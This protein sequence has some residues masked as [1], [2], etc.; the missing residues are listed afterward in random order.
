MEYEYKGRLLGA[1]IDVETTGFSPVMDEVIELCIV[2]FECDDRGSLVIEDQYVGLRE[3]SCGIRAGAQAV[4]GISWGDVCGQDLDYDRVSG[5]IRR[6]DFLVAHNATFDRSFV[7][8]LLPLADRKRWFCSMAGIDWRGK[9]YPSRGLQELLR[10]HGINPERTHRASDDV[11]ATLELLAYRQ[12]SGK[13][14]L[15]ELIRN[16]EPERF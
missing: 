10:F 1:A 2:L 13:T 5:I 9:G 7:T 6:A 4:N 12:A 8:R 3:P 15:A 16:F 11:L 14:Y